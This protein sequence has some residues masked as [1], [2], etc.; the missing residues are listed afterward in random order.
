MQ[1]MSKQDAA[2][3]HFGSEGQVRLFT[4]QGQCICLFVPLSLSLFVPLSLC[5]LVSLSLCLLVSL[6]L[7]LLVYQSLCLFVPP[8][9]P[10]SRATV[11]RTLQTLSLQVIEYHRICLRKTRFFCSIMIQQVARCSYGKVPANHQ[12][13][14]VKQWIFDDLLMLRLF[15]SQSLCLSVSLSLSPFVFLSLSPVLL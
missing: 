6:S 3:R 10:Q 13:S 15:V 1:E 2:R 7:C 11:T 5:L 14:R 8:L 12:K 9:S 4:V